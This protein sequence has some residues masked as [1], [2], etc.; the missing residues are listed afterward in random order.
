MTLDEAIFGRRSVRKFT[1]RYVTDEEIR[2]LV[3]AAGWAPSW[4]NSQAWEFIVVRDK[5]LIEQVAGTYVELN[6]ATKGSLN[7]SALIVA[8]A[9]DGVSGCYDG[10]DVT[11]IQKWYMFDLGLAVQNL[12]LKAHELGLGTVVVGYLDHEA[13]KRILDV[14]EGHE[15]VAVLPVGEPLKLAKSG[16]PRKD[17]SSFLFLDKFGKT[18]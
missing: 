3:E 4:A 1:D 18:F 13:C 2:T 6:P 17:L 7:A 9:K 8:C 11:R 5:G 16:P 14:P 15:V 10:K 12:S